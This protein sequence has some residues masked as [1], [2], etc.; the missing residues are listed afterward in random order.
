MWSFSGWVEGISDHTDGGWPLFDGFSIDEPNDVF[1]AR[2]GSFR[3]HI[4]VIG[5]WNVLIVVVFPIHEFPNIHRFLE[6]SITYH[7]SWVRDIK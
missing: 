1:F 7:N 2:W 6:E 4:F 3:S 5:E